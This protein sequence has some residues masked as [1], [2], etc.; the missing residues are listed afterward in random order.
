MK[1]APTALVKHVKRGTAYIVQGEADVQASKPINEGDK[2]VVYRSV[3]GQLIIRPVEEFD[4]GR[5]VAYG[6]K[7]PQ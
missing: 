1:F 2:V 3:T 4:D 6:T 7:G 5:F